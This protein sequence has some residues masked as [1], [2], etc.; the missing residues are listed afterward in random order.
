[1]KEKK[2]K[3]FVTIEYS[4]L[5]PVLL[6]V[7]TFLVYIGVYLH[8]QCVIQT[9]MYILAVEGA[10]LSANDTSRRISL[11]QEQEKKLYKDKCILTENIQTTYKVEGNKLI[12]SG[13]GQMINLFWKLGMGEDF[14]QLSAESS[15]CIN[16]SWNTLMLLKK[17][18]GLIEYIPSK[19][20]SDDD[21]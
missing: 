20:E 3:A 18:C 19:E 21:W 8:N 17:A 5:L 13:S 12:I 6:L 9:N 10:R 11:L 15:V 16:N 2:V 14:W 4:L 7:F 1:M